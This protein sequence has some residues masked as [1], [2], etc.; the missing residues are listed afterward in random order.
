M[1]PLVKLQLQPSKKR[2]QASWPLPRLAT[3][4]AANSPPPPRLRQTRRNIFSAPSIDRKPPCWPGLRSTRYIYRE[5]ESLHVRSR[6][7]ASAVRARA[8]RRKGAHP[9]A[10]VIAPRPQPPSPL[11]QP[12]ALPPGR[13]PPAQR[14]GGVLTYQ[15]QALHRARD[16]VPLRERRS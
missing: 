13:A 3:G 12:Q 2:N 14:V 4:S 1:S 15:L 8:T 10:P 16:E 6:A 5:R 9:P 7:W 11:L